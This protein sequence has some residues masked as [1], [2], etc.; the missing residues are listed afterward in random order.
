MSSLG[1][2]S[3]GRRVSVFMNTD[4]LSPRQQ[5]SEGEQVLQPLSWKNVRGKVAHVICGRL[6][7][8]LRQGKIENKVRS[9]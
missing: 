9:D 3:E 7:G 4:A 1:Q 8:Y 5:N 2:E 6:T